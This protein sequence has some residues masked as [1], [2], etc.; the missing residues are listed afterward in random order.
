MFNEG[1][2]EDPAYVA[3]LK[4]AFRLSEIVTDL[5]QHHAEPKKVEQFKRS[6]EILQQSLGR[7]DRFREASQGFKEELESIAQ[8]YPELTG[9]SADL[10]CTV[11]IFVR[12]HALP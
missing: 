4:L 10:Q 2:E 7:G 3:L 5:E 11:D 12:N 8:S 9:K 1:S 6:F